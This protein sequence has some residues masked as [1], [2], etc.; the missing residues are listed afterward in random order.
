MYSK[1]IFTFMAFGV[2]RL[3]AATS[4]IQYGDKDVLGTGAYSVDP[5]TGATLIGLQP[6]AVTLGAPAV[7]HSFPFSPSVGDYPGTDQIYTGSIQTAFGDGY[8]VSNQRVS[9][10]QVITLD[11]SALLLS[12]QVKTFTLGIGADDFENLTW[13]QPFIA[14]INGNQH[15]ALTNTLNNLINQT[16]PYTQFF[17]IGIDPDILSPTKTL[18][19]EIDNLGNGSDGWAI[20]FLTVGVEV[21]PEP[22]SIVLLLLGGLPLIRRHRNG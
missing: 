4:I 11:Y 2:C 15:L 12:E 14:R 13:G 18:T 9:G 21:I 5:V 8:S 3:T 1:I 16:G 22:S 19:L 17:S 6:N 10:P 7:I 20:D